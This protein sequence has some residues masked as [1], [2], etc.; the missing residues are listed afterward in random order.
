M[1]ACVCEREREIDVCLNYHIHPQASQLNWAMAG[2]FYKELLVFRGLL[3]ASFHVHEANL[4][5]GRSKR[6][7]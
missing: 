4:W 6:A 3:L 5:N 7:N 2:C 1:Y